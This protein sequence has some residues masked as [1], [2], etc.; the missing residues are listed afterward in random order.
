MELAA[1]NRQRRE[2]DYVTVRVRDPYSLPL[3]CGDIAAALELFDGREAGITYKEV[4]PDLYEVTARFITRPPE[5][6]E[7]LSWR[8]YTY[9][10]G[11]V[12]LESC[13]RCGVPLELRHLELDLVK[14]IITIMPSGRRMVG[15]GSS[16]LEAVFDELERELG[17][18]I[19]QVVIDAQRRFVA[20][21]FYSEVEISGESDLRKQ[22][23]LRGLGNLREMEVGD[24]RL[25]IRLENACLHLLI[26]GLLQGFFELTYDCKSEVEWDLAEDDVLTVKVRAG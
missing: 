7:R 1:I 3:V 8:E 6:K 9:K 15:I 10:D 5:L 16:A 11:D 13:P 22:L 26:V 12:G 20:A 17:E 14:G 19:P 23:A 18:T 24:K 2:G 25:W 4:A 21:G